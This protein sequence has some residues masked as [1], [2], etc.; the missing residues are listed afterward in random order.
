M[1]N[2]F[3]TGGSGTL[4]RALT[5]WLLDNGHAVT[6]FSRGEALQAD[7]RQR[8]PAVRYVLGDV[9]DYDRL[10]A[11][12]AGHDVV[13]HAAAMKRIPEC[14]Q[15]PGECYATNVTGSMNVHRACT[16]HGVELCI[17]ISTD[18]ACRPV[19]A[20]GA[21]KLMM[22]RLWQQPQT[23]TV[24]TLVRYGNVLE[25]R[26]SV[27]PLW[28]RQYAETGSI[29]ITHPAMTRFWMTPAQAVEAVVSAWYHG[30]GEIV[31]PKVKA[32]PVTTMA[33]YIVPDAERLTTGLRSMERIHEYLVS[34]EEQA[35]EYPEHFVITP[36]HK[37][38]S[39]CYSSE[40]A[41][42]LSRPEFLAMLEEAHV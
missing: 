14:E 5:A 38:V 32:L 21:S 31:V 39:R 13:I 10:S 41:P 18:K 33:A 25:S 11:A 16:L 6:I 8:F 12:V 9:R 2:V 17:G 40:D 4:G 15:Q 28:R 34:P 22:E 29:T 36:H 26:G 19:T 30:H 20:Y 7:M 27:I 42:R 35:L 37:G 3:I 1:S 23:S 24:F